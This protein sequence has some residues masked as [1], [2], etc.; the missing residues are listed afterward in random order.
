MRYG[1][2]PIFRTDLLCYSRVIRL[3]DLQCTLDTLHHAK[4]NR[5]KQH[6]NSYPERVPL[7]PVPP[8]VPP[9][10]ERRRPRLV[11]SLF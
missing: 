10:R 9:V 5:Q 8:V 3:V 11:E 2:I 1:S 7:H 6:H 4:E